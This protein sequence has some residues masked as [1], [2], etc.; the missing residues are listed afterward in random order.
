MGQVQSHPVVSQE[1]R[2]KKVKG[3]KKKGFFH[4]LSLLTCVGMEE[5]RNDA[6]S[7]PTNDDTDSES[8]L[9]ADGC[10]MHHLTKSLQ[11]LDW[12]PIEKDKDCTVTEEEEELLLPLFSPLSGPLLLYMP[13]WRPAPSSMP[14]VVQLTRAG[15]LLMTELTSLDTLTFFTAPVWLHHIPKIYFTQA[16]KMALEELVLRGQMTSGPLLPWEFSPLY[17]GPVVIWTGE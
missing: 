12:S 15:K 4:F 2:P 9:S 1:K 7:I 14:A 5:R 16:G 3:K 13:V 6:S 11:E 17:C 8:S 10:V